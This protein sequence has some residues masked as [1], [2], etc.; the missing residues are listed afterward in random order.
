MDRKDSALGASDKATARKETAPVS[1]P[2]PAGNGSQAPQEAPQR[3]KLVKGIN[4]A[5][6]ECEQKI[7]NIINSSGLPACVLYFSL[8]KI[9]DELREQYSALTV[10]EEQQFMR[11]KATREEAEKNKTEG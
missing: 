8:S 1:Q 9:T 10:R 2:T 5:A 4:Y 6:R 7:V 11:E 3:P